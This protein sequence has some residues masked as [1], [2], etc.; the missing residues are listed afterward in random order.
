MAKLAPPVY[1]FPGHYIKETYL[2]SNLKRT[3]YY[4]P[5][6]I[7]YEEKIKNRQKR[8]KNGENN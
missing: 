2:P 7:G 5:K 4:K 8:G 3:I 6:D 1:N